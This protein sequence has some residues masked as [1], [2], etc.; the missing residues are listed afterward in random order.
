MV[1]AGLAL[2]PRR[3]HGNASAEL[4][5]RVFMDRKLIVFVVC[6]VSN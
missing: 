3:S 1:A 4:L 2:Y 5:K 6:E